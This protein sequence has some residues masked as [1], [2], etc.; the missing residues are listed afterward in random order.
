[1]TTRIPSARVNATDVLRHLIGMIAAEIP[2]DAVCVCSYDDETDVYELLAHDLFDRYLPFD[3]EQ[4]QNVIRQHI[5]REVVADVET[6]LLGADALRGTP[7]Q[8]SLVFRLAMLDKLAGLL[9]LFAVDADHFAA[10]VPARLALPVSMIGMAIENLHLYDLLAR[11]MVV[12]E[13]IFE[14]TRLIGQ[15]PSPQNI[16][17]VLRDYLFDSHVSGCTILLYGPLR[18]DRPY[19]PF[20]YLEVAA[21]WSKAKNSVIASGTKL[22]LRDSLPALDNLD[23]GEPIVFHR[24]EDLAN[25]LDPFTRSLVRASEVASITLLPLRSGER[26][27]GMIAIGTEHPH[28]FSAQELETYQAVSEFLAISAM[29]QVLQQQHDRVAE[30]RV[31]LLDAVTEGV[32][33]ILP[34]GA[35]GR[36]LTVNQRFTTIFGVSEE[37]AQGMLLEDLLAQMQLP[38]AERRKLGDLWFDLSLRDPATQRGEFRMVHSA[39]YPLDIEWYSAP[40]YEKNGHVLGRIYTFHDVTAER[41]AVRVRSDF[42]TRVSHELRTPLTSIHGFAEFILEVSG[43][44]LPPLAREY[45]Q[46]IFNSAKHLRIMFTDMIE[47]T[48]ADAGELRLNMQRTHLPDIVLEAVARLELEHKRRNQTVILD[49]DDEVPRVNIDPDR[50]VQ[51]LSNL[52]MNAIKYSPENSRIWVHLN[53][54]DELPPGAPADVLIP[55]LLV[56]IVD[57]GEGLAQADVDQIFLPFFR[58]DW[59][60]IHKVEGTGL[61]L[62]VSRSIIEL[63]RGTLWAQAATEAEPGGR[64]LFTIPM[65]SEA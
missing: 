48:R 56:S 27:L 3:M 54:V 46:I 35:S 9:V 53:Q 51:V 23:R 32:V 57:E 62:A 55:A 65:M 2:V 18:E 12:S 26:K 10:D 49:L 28:K 19:G 21:S 15:N 4:I 61:G 60:R 33:M 8:S 44:K 52:L 64:F 16:V 30:G 43:D 41:T 50:I 37:A 29:S 38:E 63:H 25:T 20:D 42:L 1:M 14:T 22:Y 24:A 31:A 5:R 59:A 58:T 45:T 7:F 13:A 36:V 17:E 11:Q 6:L 34:E 40:V 47:M 39:G